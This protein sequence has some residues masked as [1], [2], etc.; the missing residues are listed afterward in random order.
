MNTPV[1]V[2]RTAVRPGSPWSQVAHRLVKRGFPPGSPGWLRVLG[3]AA[4]VAGAG[5]MVATAAIHLHLWLAGYR[6]VPR[7]GPLFLAQS[8]T[9]FAAA[10]LVA[11]GRQTI[12]VLGAA[13]YMVASAVGLVLSATVG[14]LGIHDGLGVPWATTS[15]AVELA[16]FVLLAGG[17]LLQLVRR[18]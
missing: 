11:V 9:G 3:T 12:V 17:G 5:L 6:H 2:Q 7:I 16:G 1:T 15:L 13:V 8:I 14:F 18:G 10:P 4:I